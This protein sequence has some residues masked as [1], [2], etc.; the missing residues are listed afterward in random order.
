MLVYENSDNVDV[1]TEKG[2][3]GDIS[4]KKWDL[5]SSKKMNWAC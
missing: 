1:G 2:R 4:A 5:Y 3:Q